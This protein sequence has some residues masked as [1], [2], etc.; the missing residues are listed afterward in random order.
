MGEGMGVGNS[1]ETLLSQ[2]STTT[3]M[4]LSQGGGGMS[5]QATDL[6]QAQG[7]TQV[8]CLTFIHTFVKFDEFSLKLSPK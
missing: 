1:Q 5:S 4:S 8:V 3:S 7:L 6:S 2:E